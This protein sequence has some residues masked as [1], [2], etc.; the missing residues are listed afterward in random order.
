MVIV[1]SMFIPK[2]LQG[3]DPY[4]TKIKYAERP[5]VSGCDRS[6]RCHCDHGIWRVVARHTKW[7]DAFVGW[8]LERSL[9]LVMALGTGTSAVRCGRLQQS[10]WLNTTKKLAYDLY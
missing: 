3:G 6:P 1:G 8:S 5:V 4:T 9:A 2:A 7:S 10:Y